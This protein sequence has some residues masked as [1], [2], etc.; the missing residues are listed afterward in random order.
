MTSTLQVIEL[1]H[2]ATHERACFGC[3]GDVMSGREPDTGLLV[4]LCGRCGE[5]LPWTTTDRHGHAV[6]GFLS[7]RDAARW[8]MPQHNDDRT[9]ALGAGEP[10]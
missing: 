8:P 4:S 6:P 1:I 5:V 10:S 2:E 7:S 3:G 9:I